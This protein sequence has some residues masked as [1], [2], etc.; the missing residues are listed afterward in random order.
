MN[1][2]G[3]PNKEETKLFLSNK[4]AF[5]NYIS[6]DFNETLKELN[7]YDYS[8]EINH[9]IYK[10]SVIPVISIHI[11][12][13]IPVISTQIASIIQVISTQIASIIPVICGT[14]YTSDGHGECI[15]VTP[16][17]VPP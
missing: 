6:K 14:G 13:I 9:N 11:A 10:I 17:Y 7:K 5:I 16:S 8:K 4:I 15:E 3:I 12:S 2:N 1:S